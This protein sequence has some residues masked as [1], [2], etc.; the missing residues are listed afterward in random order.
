MPISAPSR[1][2][3]S[4]MFWLYCGSVRAAAQN[5]S[6]WLRSRHS[7]AQRRS[8]DPGMSRAR[9]PC[10]LSPCLTVGGHG[11]AHVKGRGE[12]ATEGPKV[13]S[14]TACGTAGVYWIPLARRLPDV[15]PSDLASG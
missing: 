6:C 1:E 5:L 7:R 2:A 13:E 15:S 11:A 9:C 4:A 3:T 12:H 8:L 14:G 10:E